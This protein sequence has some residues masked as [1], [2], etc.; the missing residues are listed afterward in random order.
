MVLSVPRHSTHNQISEYLVHRNGGS[1]PHFG[2]S[3]LHITRQFYFF[4][5]LGFFQWLD[6]VL[7]FTRIFPGEALPNFSS[8]F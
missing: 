1:Y 8:C 5:V 2:G 4:S 6:L 7:Y 3:Y